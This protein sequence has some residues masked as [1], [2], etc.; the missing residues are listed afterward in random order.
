MPDY[1]RPHGKMAR[2]ERSSR[3]GQYWDTEFESI[4]ALS[5]GVITTK[6]DYFNKNGLGSILGHEVVDAAYLRRRCEL[7]GCNKAKM[8][9]D[10]RGFAFCPICQTIYN[11]G[12]PPI[13]TK[14][15]VQLLKAAAIRK[16]NYKAALRKVA[17]R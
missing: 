11:D 12:Q 4:Y 7:P 15:S 2:A 16:Q 17:R 1:R 10:P 3:E 13:R 5:S 8:E 6:T 9:I 14:T